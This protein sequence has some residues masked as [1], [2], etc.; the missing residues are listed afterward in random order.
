MKITVLT[1]LFLATN[2]LP[3]IAAAPRSIVEP[4]RSHRLADAANDNNNNLTPQQ[5]RTQSTQITVRIS[6]ENN[7]G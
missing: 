4:P 2:L 3:V 6:S 7:G 5:I 1:A